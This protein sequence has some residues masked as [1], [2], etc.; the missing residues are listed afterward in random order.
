[1]LPNQIVNPNAIILH[2][3]L[4]NDEIRTFFLRFCPWLICTYLITVENNVTSKQQQWR[5]PLNNPSINTDQICMGFKADTPENESKRAIVSDFLD[6]DLVK[7]LLT[8]NLIFSLF[9]RSL[10]ERR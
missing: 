6:K 2:S 1:M 4:K 10:S 3:S 8:S 5:I 7:K 9:T